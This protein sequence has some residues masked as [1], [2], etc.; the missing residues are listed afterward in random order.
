M[1]RFKIAV[2][3]CGSMSSAWIEI[4]LSR[5]DIDIVA[6]VDISEENAENMREKYGLH[7]QIRWTSS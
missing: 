4:A 6:L 5:E 7:C 2:V 1:K 3:G